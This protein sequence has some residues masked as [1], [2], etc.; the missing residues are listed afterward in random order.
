[1]GKDMNIKSFK[2]PLGSNAS[3]ALERS[4]LLRGFERENR[5]SAHLSDPRRNSSHRRRQRLLCTRRENRRRF[6]LAGVARGLRPDRPTRDASNRAAP[7][8]PSEAGLV[9]LP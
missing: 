5:N 8:P 7:W 4:T 9:L 2:T 6:C 1:M 3:L